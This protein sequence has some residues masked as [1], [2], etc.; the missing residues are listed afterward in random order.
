MQHC[1]KSSQHSAVVRY[2]LFWYD[3]KEEGRRSPD[4][5]KKKENRL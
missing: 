2:P 5:K 1:D 4:G 3:K